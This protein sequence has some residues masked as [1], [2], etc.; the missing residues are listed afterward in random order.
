MGKHIV[1]YSDMEANCNGADI[2]ELVH[3][4]EGMPLTVLSNDKSTR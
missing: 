2:S 4:I 3:E 1:L